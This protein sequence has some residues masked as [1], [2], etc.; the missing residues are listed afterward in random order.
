V[1]RERRSPNGGG[2]GGSAFS[3]WGGKRSGS[4]SRVVNKADIKALRRLAR[5]TTFSAWGG[6]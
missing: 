6:K 5:S 1:K 4:P 2:G 3:T